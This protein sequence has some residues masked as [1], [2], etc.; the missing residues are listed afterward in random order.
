M[1]T[2]YEIQCNINDDHPDWFRLGVW[3]FEPHL[4]SRFLDY[5][6]ELL[7]VHPIETR[8][9]LRV[10]RVSYV[11]GNEA[12]EFDGKHHYKVAY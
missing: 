7:R 4:L 11:Y 5:L 9:M 1:L 12:Y 6:W 2:H 10:R 8:I 3:R